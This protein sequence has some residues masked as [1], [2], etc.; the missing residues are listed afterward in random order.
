MYFLQPPRAFL[1]PIFLFLLHQSPPAAKGQ[2]LVFQ[3]VM[4]GHLAITSLS[5]GITTLELLAEGSDFIPEHIPSGQ[6]QSPFNVATQD[7]IFQLESHGPRNFY[8]GHV[9]PPGKI[10]P[11]SIDGT[12]TDDGRGNNSLA[13]DG[14]LMIPMPLG[15]STL[16][17]LSS[18][19]RQAFLFLWTTANAIRPTVTAWFPAI[20]STIRSGP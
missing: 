11:F 12:L 9:L 8:F 5:R 3:G 13:A 4:D 7:K 20:V 16:L 14:L 18:N 2:V 1:F 19:F 10:I 6:L 15:P 17:S